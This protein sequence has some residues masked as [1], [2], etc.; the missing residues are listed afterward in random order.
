MDISED[1]LDPLMARLA[2]GDRSVFS[3]VFDLL[4][5]P[6]HRLC[7]SLLRNSADADD[8]AQEAMAKILERASDYDRQRA[9]MPWALA[10]AGWECRTLS[11]KRFRRREVGEEEAGSGGTADAEESFISRDLVK[12]ALAALGELSP[13]DR[14]A[15][16]A[17]YW[18]ETA[19]VTGPTLRKRRERA[20]DRLRTLFRR[21]YGLD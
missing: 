13:T 15:L 4:W 3:A 8:A 16:I 9:A 11:R 7:L 2:Q 1:R 18:D 21:V 20:L 6:V 5:G 12:A 17:T 14:E 10:I 19:S